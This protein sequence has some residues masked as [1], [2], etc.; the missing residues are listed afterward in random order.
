VETI[1]GEQPFRVLA[2]VGQILIGNVPQ[3]GD[4]SNSLP[5][6]WALNHQMVVEQHGDGVG[7]DTAAQWIERILAS[8]E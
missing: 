5:V 4:G 6:Y 8:H 1:S 2:D 7:L 3:D